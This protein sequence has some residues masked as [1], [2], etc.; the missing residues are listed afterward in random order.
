M[1]VT[2]PGDKGKAV[3]ES[4]AKSPGLGGAGGPKPGEG[5][6]KQERDSGLYDVLFAGLM[7]DGARLDVVVTGDR[8]PRATAPPAR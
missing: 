3:A 1:M 5:P 7:P 8:N 6:S 4:I 2:G